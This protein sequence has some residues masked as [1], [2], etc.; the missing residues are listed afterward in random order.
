MAT[1]LLSSVALSVGEQTNVVTIVESDEA[2]TLELVSA[3]V[4]AASSQA[5]V[6]CLDALGH[7][8]LT[9]L[10]NG[11]GTE[12]K[13]VENIDSDLTCRVECSSGSCRVTLNQLEGS[14][15]HGEGAGGV[16]TADLADGSV[17]SAKI[18][19]LAVDA[20]ALGAAAVETAKLDAGAV[21]GAKMD[22]AGLKIL[23][24]VGNNGAS[25]TLTMTGSIA[26][27]RVIAVF[28][29]PTAGTGALVPHPVGVDFNAV[30]PANDDIDQLSVAD[31]SS[32]TLIVFVIPA[33]S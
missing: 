14:E 32:D 17:T 8:K 29:T 5:R 27:E 7:V 19:A 18:E 33:A 26:G 13:T 30:I 2:V 4:G 16:V 6:V 12:Q 11:S 25:T 9:L 24:G 3:Q 31:L 15:K 10:I 1:T 21:T 28:A 20:A 22:F 23:G